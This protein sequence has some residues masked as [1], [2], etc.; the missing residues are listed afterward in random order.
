[1][2]TPKKKLAIHRGFTITEL[3]VT[4]MLAVIIMCGISFM[5]VDSQQGWHRM[6]NSIYSD[7]ITDSYVARKAFDAVVRKA[8]SEKLLLA[9][10]GTWL[11]VYYYADANAPSPDRY[12][13][14]YYSE[15]SQT[16]TGA[17]GQLNIEHGRVEPRETLNIQTVCGNVSSCVFKAA[18][19]SAQ[20]ILTLDNGQQTITVVSSSVMHNQ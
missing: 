12:A 5:M 2:T 7:V 14:F 15:S 19:R 6:Y 16:E 11:E 18:G 3:M 10:D 20:M 9:E 4:V 1:M 13:R 8:S 17:E